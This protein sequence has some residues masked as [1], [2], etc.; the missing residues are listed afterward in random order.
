M[1]L[2][3]FF[4]YRN[5]S[6]SGCT[7]TS[8]CTAPSLRIQQ[9]R[10][11]Y[12]YQPPS[13][14][15]RMG[16]TEFPKR[17][18]NFLKELLK[19]QHVCDIID[20]PPAHDSMGRNKIPTNVLIALYLVEEYKAQLLN[21]RLGEPAEEHKARK[22]SSKDSK[23]ERRAAET[24]EGFKARMDKLPVVSRAFRTID[25]TNVVQTLLQ[26][27]RNHRRNRD[28]KIPPLPLPEKK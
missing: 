18:T 14:T 16:Y 11:R 8:E 27:V 26:W 7:F 23:C 17:E 3:F 20:G 10:Y 24:D 21:P 13:P 12:V 25:G 1:F 6:R 9:T 28:V 2:F 5:L 4:Y 19:S 22:K 15:C